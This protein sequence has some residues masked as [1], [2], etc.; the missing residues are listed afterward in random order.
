MNGL[1]PDAEY[2]PVG[3]LTECSVKRFLPNSVMTYL[4]EEIGSNI[5]A[6]F[7]AESLEI[8]PGNEESTLVEG[9]DWPP[10]EQREYFVSGNVMV[11]CE[12]FL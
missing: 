3:K 10:I 11:V 7:H 2:G 6:I 9:L 4:F 5:N 8:E 1:I 12:I